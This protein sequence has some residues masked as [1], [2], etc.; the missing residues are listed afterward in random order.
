MKSNLYL[1]LTDRTKQIFKTVVESYLETGSPSGS[2]TVLKKAGLD[3]SSASVRN[4]LSNLQKEGLLFSPHTSAGRVPTE[5]G[6]RF[7]V[8]GLL[9]FGRI[10]KS[11]KENIEQLSSSKSKSYQEVLDEA[12]R[13]ISGLSNYAGIVIAP[14]YQKN[15]KHLEFIRLNQT[16]VMSI[17]AY[18][19]GEI[20]N[21]I[22][23][24]RGRFTNSQL[25]QTS[26]Y[27]SDKFKNKNIN[28]IKKIIEDEITNTRSS[29]EQISRKLVE[30]GIVEIEPK[31]NNP[32]IFLHGQSK[33][34]K[35]EIISKDLDE[36]RQLFD[37]IENKTTFID[38]LE[39][40][41]KAKGVQIFIGSKNFLFKHSGLSMVMAPYKNREQKIVGAIGVVGP[42]RL[43]YSKIVPLVDYTSKVIGKVVK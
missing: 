2:E 8:D 42:T 26:N 21:R 27:L 14:K 13:A 1:E 32:Y 17:L 35:D 18:E 7:F 41:G 19:N 33:L 25:L 6:M 23:E 9:E 12:S 31:I 4:I 38:I 29:L 10:S 34:L 24:D 16:Q 15:L 30:K 3:I 40:A 20:E 43:N 5:K 22:I 37:E 11:E 36:I 39:N 28:E